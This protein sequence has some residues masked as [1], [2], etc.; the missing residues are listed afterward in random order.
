M[1][2]CKRG[3]ALLL[4]TVMLVMVI[5]FGGLTAFA[6]AIDAGQIYLDTPATA[7]IENGGDIASFTFIPPETG[8]YT[9]RSYSDDDTRGYIY[10]E[11]GSCLASDD[12]GAG[13][14][15]F[16]IT[17][18]LEAGVT[19]KLQT[20]YH[21]NE[22]TGSYEVKVYKY[23]PRFVE[24]VEF[25]TVEIPVW[26]YSNFGYNDPESGKYFYWKH[27]NYLPS[28]TV[29]FTDGTSETGKSQY[30]YDDRGS[31]YIEFFD[32][33][34]YD[35]QWDVGEHT[36]EVAIPELGIEDTFTVSIKESPV[37]SVEVP[38]LQIIENANGYYKSDSVYDE[39]GDYIGETPEYFYY[40]TP[41]LP[42]NETVIHFKDGSSITG[43]AFYWNNEY[44]SVDY[45][46]PEQTYE[47]RQ[48]VGNTYQIECEIAGYEFSYDIEIVESPVASVEIQPYE[49]FEG[50]NGYYTTG[51]RDEN[52]EWNSDTPEY[53]YYH[54][55]TPYYEHVTITLKDGT[56]IKGTE[57]E[58][59]GESYNVEFYGSDQ[60]YYHQW[61][62]GNT[63]QLE[64][65]IA[66]FDFTYDVSIVE[67]PVASIIVDPI[68][69]LENEYGNYTYDNY[70]DE[71][72]GE[73]VNSP[74]YYKYETWIG[75][76]QMTIILK[77]GS[78]IENNW[79]EWNGEEYGTSYT[80]PQCY[81][82]Q[83]TVGNTYQA[84][85]TIAGYRF[86]YDITISACPVASVEVAPI[87]IS[88]NHNGWY[89]TDSLYDE[90]GDYIGE[91]PEYFRY[92]TPHPY[93]DGTVIT[94]TDG[95][96][97][98]AN[99]F[100]WNGRE[101]HMSIYEPEQS[102]ENQWTAGNT[103]QLR[104]EIMNFEFTFE[105]KIAASP[106]A[107]VEIKPLQII[108]NTDGYYKNGYWSNDEWVDSPE[109][110]YYHTPHP[111]WED[112]TIT[113][114]DG[115]VIQGTSFEWNG[116]HY[117][118][119]TYGFDQNYQNR[120][121]VGNTYQIRGEIAGFEFSYDVE[122]VESPV[123]YVEIAPI[124]YYEGSNGQIGRDEYWDVDKQEWIY[125]PEYFKYHFYS[126]QF[127][128]H[129]K[130]GSV[131]D[132]GW[133]YWNGREYSVCDVENED[134]QRYENQWTAGN[135]YTQTRSIAGYVFDFEV[136]IAETPV[137]SIVVNKVY[138]MMNRSG[139]YKTDPIW[140]EH[141]NYIIG[142][143]PEYFYHHTPYPSGPD[144][145]ITM[146]DGTVINNYGFYLDGEW[147]SINT[148]GIPQSYD[149]Q[150]VAGQTYTIEAEFLGYNFTYECEF[151]TS[152]VA[153]IEIKP[154]QIIEGNGGYYWTDPLYDENGNHIGESPEYF[155]YETPW[156]RWD[157][158][159]ITLKDGT[160][161]NDNSFY[162]N[163]QEYYFS[164][165]ENYQS[166]ENQWTAGNSYEIEYEI[167]GFSGTY[168]VEIVQLSS[169]DSFEYM[170]SEDGVIITDSFIAPETLEIPADINGKP[171]IGVAYLSGYDTIKHLIFPDTVETIGDYVLQEF[172]NLETVT[173]GSSVRNLNT[174][175]FE[176]AYNLTGITVA[177]DNE[178]YTV[179]NGALYDKDVTK[180]FAYPITLGNTFVVP[181]TVVDIGAL[182]LPIYS[183][184]EFV[185]PED[186]P[187]FVTVD[188]V[189]YDKDM[190]MVLFCSKSKEGSY[191][192]P[193]TVTDIA[194][195]AFEGCDQLTEVIVSANVT[196]IVY[197]T[198]AS[199]ASLEKVDLPNGLVSIDERAFEGTS[200]LEEIELP[201]TLKYIGVLAFANSGLTSL[202][203]PDSVDIIDSSAFRD[204]NI[205][206]L[207]LGNGIAEIY[208]S[209]F[210]NTPVTSV[211]LP[212]SL[213]WL[214]SGAFYHCT[215]LKAVS[216]SNN[217]NHIS[218]S[219]FAY[220]ALEELTLPSNIWHIEEYA[221]CGSAIANL[222]LNEEL[223]E[224]G[225]CAFENCDNLLSVEIPD[226]VYY[227]G[228]GAF[229][230][231]DSLASVT[232]GDG[233]EFMGQYAFANCPITSLDMGD[234]LEFIAPYAFENT[235]LNSAFIPDSVT[236]I[237]Y[238]AFMDCSQLTSIELPLSVESID[239]D[240]FAYC[241]NLTD[242]YYQGTE[243]DRAN[244]YIDECGNEYL[245]NATWHY[246]WTNEKW[247]GEPVAPPVGPDEPDVCEHAYD[248]ACD[249]ECNLCGEIRG[250]P[251][252]VYENAC[253]VDCN[254]CGENRKPAAHVYDNNCDNSCNE[255]G[256]N[257]PDFADHVY[258][259]ACD[260]DCNECGVIREVPSHVYENACDVDCNECGENRKPAAHVYDNNCD[261]SC[262]ECG[263]ANPD[264]A[265]HVYDNACDVD[266]NECGEN[267]KPADHVY[268]DQYDA[269]CNVCGGI[270]VVPERPIDP[271]VT[272]GPMFIVDGAT[273]K[274]GDTITVAVR[275]EKNVGIVSLMLD[276]GYDA[277]VLELISITGKD[278]N[279][280]SF[281]PLN[282]NPI[283]VN[284]LDALNPNNTT[285]GTIALLTFKV[286]DEAAV[287]TTSITVSYDAEN[288]YDFDINN[289]T[290]GTQNG[291]IEIIDYI[292]GDLND[293]GIV[294]NKDLGLLQRYINRW[295]VDINL[296]AAN[297]NGD[298]V[299]NNKDLGLLQRYI[300]RWDVELM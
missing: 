105:V 249:A 165:D 137:E 102:Y 120:W 179:I 204:T 287:G 200:A 19:Y 252:H 146:K 81:D 72:L 240:A 190:T 223:E 149:N 109:Y 299:I 207:D 206:T 41:T 258:D 107:S 84:E 222:A 30:I 295:D 231:C 138:D 270:R 144:V 296:A 243:Q 11:D 241:E 122:I 235:D 60:D 160:V 21:N 89:T 97:I 140:D 174:Y 78:V 168:T 13:D 54:E 4:A 58:W 75:N 17:E 224:I 125:S 43:T 114:T 215:Q 143:T 257:N 31:Y 213:K 80:N 28:Y 136:T 186:H 82:N 292:P 175:M 268:D 5:P 221:F 86:T 158:T 77:D 290:F 180:L 48:T 57:I 242:V 282:S 217:L 142:Y 117:E 265:D 132:L 280:V 32:D 67:S 90:N 88:E 65:K 177:E 151:I 128:I 171:V 95:T 131:H 233:I 59:N 7:V 277:N 273:A 23:V 246:E 216:F 145:V 214:G 111:Q 36:I 141:G 232:L 189:T 18:M 264:F 70:Y 8:E 12:D 66:G 134:D 46:F 176:Y 192:M 99:W 110:Y 87:E 16:L 275:T 293:D 245:L 3:L 218:D 229:M 259:N 35:N 124:V 53:F 211:T 42:Y 201:E 1:S 2:K 169:N 130:D 118:M 91:T 210:A 167:A 253:D 115:T 172:Y 121:T 73:W 156:P 256:A 20:R 85:A 157:S 155:R 294:N 150:I 38:S 163:G 263:A 139:Y 183:N 283:A 39:D 271:P 170:E 199:C 244:I 278:F 116:K 55:P 92:H 196:E 15:N 227:I 236:D 267:R 289:V 254:E 225:S 274:A 6:S 187:Y 184:V 83:W 203:V 251:D 74:E 284:W 279:G 173:F 126:S 52:H 166:Y 164:V 288:V 197:C 79:F 202:T 113:L 272:D 161:I 198:F 27:Y 50:S 40:Y 281:G 193:D 205:A 228:G 45:T 297:V 195:G 194:E 260:V 123:D 93:Y 34:A 133:F 94:L 62:V 261:N 226:S 178:N 64:G 159:I 152:P 37:A 101:Y 154:I 26:K 208:E 104:G 220:T 98:N 10:D 269:D 14:G 61:T 237:M 119:S 9:F 69:R 291:T 182:M 234:S 276:I 44:F 185:F 286:K 47:N 127:V 100:E 230:D 262:N 51:Y 212:D 239:F 300:N 108:E 147:V 56:V 25:S 24:S 209:A 49:F 148:D 153:S 219:C 188:G 247:D 191:T 135:T 255:C 162:W 181:N 285:N 29:Y 129:L 298:T 22:Y 238:G 106:I 71:E 248:N 33:Q 96:V 63:Y 103:Y 76:D 266:C 250:V 68:I 112:V